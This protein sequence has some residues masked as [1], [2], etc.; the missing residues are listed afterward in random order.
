MSTGVRTVNL[1]RARKVALS[2]LTSKPSNKFV[3]KTQ[4]RVPKFKGRGF[5]HLKDRIPRF[6]I[7]KGDRVRM[8]VGAPK[9]KFNDAD[10]GLISG[11]KVYTVADVDKTTNR[12][13]LEG[14][15]N[16]RANSPRPLPADFDSL[17]PET[18]KEWTE[19]KNWVATQR[20]VQ[21]SNVQLCVEE[22]GAESVFATRVSTSP[23]VFDR[24]TNRFVWERFAAKTSAP[25]ANPVDKL[26]GQLRIPW[27]VVEASK[28][29]AP[30]AQDTPKSV[31]MRTTL[32]LAA[33]TDVPATLVPNS[34]RA[35]APSD[36]TWANKY[37]FQPNA[38]AQ[39]ALQA[40]MPLYLSEE[41][42]PRFSRAKKQS[43]WTARRTAEAEARAV[44]VK[45]AVDAWVASGKDK[46]L[47]ELLSN[48]LINL[49]GV[50][51][52][53]RTENEVGEVAGRAF[54]EEIRLA[55]REVKHHAAAGRVFKDGQ[56][57]AGDKGIK[58]EAKR[59]R[60]ERKARKTLER[61]QSLTL[62]D[63]KNQVVPPDVRKVGA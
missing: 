37:I 49:A 39:G 21:Y 32:K 14:L 62:E 30:T 60:K 35:P 27:P 63:A 43:G 25:T 41:L 5:V 50:Q 26:K 15:T 54:D 56:W 46:G 29:E 42:S 34:L 40:A 6:N 22:A 9:D 10:A 1:E 48:D 61:L 55:R 31:A 13:Y 8:T 36:Q 59:A 57:V 47:S 18:Q 28:P 23:P 12:V 7:I 52:R 2:H 24:A 20:P 45:A 44:A 4:G 33:P 3:H 17:S 51:I 11:Y 16:R 19:Q 58:L 38:R 53:P